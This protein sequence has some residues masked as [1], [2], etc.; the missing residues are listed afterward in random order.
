MYSLL[1]ELS[2][3]QR[4][5]ISISRAKYYLSRTVYY[6]SNNII[7]QN[8]KRGTYVGFC[9]SAKNHFIDTD[10]VRWYLVYLFY[11]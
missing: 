7:Q 1:K 9:I 4:M 3:G 6:L 8:L 11:L 5:I 10:S 2:I